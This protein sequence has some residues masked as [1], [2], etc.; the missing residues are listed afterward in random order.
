MSIPFV[1]LTGTDRVS[2]VDNDD[3]EEGQRAI[4]KLQL[5]PI[6]FLPFFLFYPSTQEHRLAILCSFLPL[7]RTMSLTLVSLSG[8]IGNK[9]L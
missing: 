8:L 7:L 6:P 3:L 2:T 4:T 1:L 5:R 9:R